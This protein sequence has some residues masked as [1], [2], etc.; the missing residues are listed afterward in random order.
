MLLFALQICCINEI[1]HA[2]CI[3][4]VYDIHCCR[5]LIS[6]RAKETCSVEYQPN[7]NPKCAVRSPRIGFFLHAVNFISNIKWLLSIIQNMLLTS[8][9]KHSGVDVKE[10]WYLIVH[11]EMQILEVRIQ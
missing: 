6:R 9:L 2:L 1:C 3:S 5:K 8:L 7:F 10:L 11:W 4:S